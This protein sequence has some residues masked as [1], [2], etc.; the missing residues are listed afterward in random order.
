MFPANVEHAPLTVG[1]IIC[2]GRLKARIALSIFLSLKRSSAVKKA[3]TQ[4]QIEDYEKLC[5]ARDN[6]QLL[7]PDGLRFICSAYNYDATAIG[8]HFLEVLPQIS[9]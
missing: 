6:G 2:A 8:K 7:T 9:N 4:K 1:L 5:R 3:M